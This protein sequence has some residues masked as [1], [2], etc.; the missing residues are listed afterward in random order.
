MVAI[1]SSKGFVKSSVH[2]AFGY[3]RLSRETMS[4]ARSCFFVAMGRK[5][6][7]LTVPVAGRRIVILTLSA[8][9]GKDLKLEESSRLRSFAP[10]RM[11]RTLLLVESRDRW[12]VI[13]SRADGEGSQVTK[14]LT[15]DPS[16]LKPA[17]SEREARVEWAAQ[18][19]GP[20]GRQLATGNRQP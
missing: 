13:L 4:S 10:L 18:G 2:F 7:Q 3:I 5:G 16:P 15:R 11:T 20:G 9:K 19:D 12:F 1:K 6:Y 14:P 17:L 8:A